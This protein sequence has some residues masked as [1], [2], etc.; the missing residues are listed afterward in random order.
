MMLWWGLKEQ[1]HFATNE[2]EEEERG[3]KGLWERGEVVKGERRE[4]G[5]DHGVRS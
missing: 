4:Q 5:S 2:R 3:R 1:Y